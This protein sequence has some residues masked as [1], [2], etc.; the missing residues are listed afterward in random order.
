MREV[1]S[2]RESGLFCQDLKGTGEKTITISNGVDR[3]GWKCKLL[4]RY[5]FVCDHC[6]RFRAVGVMHPG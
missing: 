4:S 1:G 3:A 6:E 5:F 2:E